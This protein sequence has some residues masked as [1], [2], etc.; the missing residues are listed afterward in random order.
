MIP[1]EVQEKIT[2]DW[3]K[4]INGRLTFYG[5][6]NKYYAFV[7]KHW[8]SETQQ[9]YMGDYDNFLL[10]YFNRV[11]LADC[12]RA[13]FDAVV[14]HVKEKRK[15][16]GRS[17]QPNI[18]NHFRLLIRRVTAAAG[19]AGVCPD[20]LWGTTYAQ[21]S[22]KEESDALRVSRQRRSLQEKEEVLV[23]QK[24][25]CDPKQEGQNMGLAMMF[26]LGLRNGEACAVCFGDLHRM[27]F[28]DGAY[29]AIYKS[30]NRGKNTWKDGGKTRNAVRMIPVPE[31]LQKLIEARRAYIL[32][33]LQGGKFLLDGIAQ[34]TEEAL[35]EAVDKLPIACVGACYD[36]GCS[37]SHLTA[38]GKQLFQS[39]KMD[40]M[41]FRQIEAEL[42]EQNM[43][44]AE[45]TAYLFRRN[46]ATQ[47]YC[48]GVP[49]PEI[50]YVLGHD[51][52][53][54]KESRDDYRNEEKLYAIA[55]HMQKRFLINQPEQTEVIP[56]PG[57]LRLQNRTYV[58]VH[59][60]PQNTKRIKIRIY[61]NEAISR[62]RIWGKGK[63]TIDVT[64]YMAQKRC[65]DQCN[66][67]EPMR[68]KY[69]SAIRD[70]GSSGWFDPKDREA[71]EV[72]A[73]VPAEV[74]AEVPAEVPAE[75][76]AET[77]AE[78]PVEESSEEPADAV[79]IEEQQ[80]VRQESLQQTD[81]C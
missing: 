68:K 7:A 52:E 2:R 49:L 62:L 5:V 40:E 78:A 50:Q 58:G 48:A 16:M 41:I 64:Q 6:L 23:C 76:D 51:I 43:Q 42:Q 32:E 18:M 38:A 47:L 33:Q 20:V 1:E 72:P 9:N 37:A 4:E 45:S 79:Q 14:E 15:E 36:K 74:S 71:A 19:E 60:D 56:E 11:A 53:D 61:S 69:M 75:A 65:R 80:P 28:H 57:Q 31:A 59:I 13:F 22:V 27:E 30:T 21:S 17:C 66:I 55:Q 35:L 81:A 8:N 73:E 24:I 46:F 12:D 10:E 44:E 26:C 29:L 25:L 67:Q 63:M 77:A 70:V 54:A 34:D 3:N 39:M